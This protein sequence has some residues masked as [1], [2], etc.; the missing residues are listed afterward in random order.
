MSEKGYLTISIVSKYL[1]ESK[2]TL[3]KL[4]QLSSEIQKTDHLLDQKVYGLYGLTDKEIKI[5]KAKYG[6]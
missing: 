2:I 5:V 3:R 6:D 4:E 1:G